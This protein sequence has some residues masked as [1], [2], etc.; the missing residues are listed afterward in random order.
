MKY[1]PECVSPLNTPIAPLNNICWIWGTFSSLSDG[2][3]IRVRLGKLMTAIFNPQVN[4]YVLPEDP[5]LHLKMC[6]DDSAGPNSHPQNIRFSGDVGGSDD[7]THV[8]K[9]TW[10]WNTDDTDDGTWAL[11]T[12]QRTERSQQQ[13]RDTPRHIHVHSE[14]SMATDWFIYYNRTLCETRNVVCL[15]SILKSTT[16]T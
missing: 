11:L 3:Q 5:V 8:L 2:S 7:S 14:R 10:V 12:V 15:E 13:V 4:H 1:N 6:L 9:E 16:A